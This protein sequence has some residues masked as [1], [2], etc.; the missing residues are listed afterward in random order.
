M[1][2]VDETFA[3]KPI[4]KI[5]S[6]LGRVSMACLQC[7][8]GSKDACKYCG[9]PEIDIDLNTAPILPKESRKNDG[10]LS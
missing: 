3:P 5:N 7:K 4:G 6:A 2:H 9:Y 1:I 10:R 8:P